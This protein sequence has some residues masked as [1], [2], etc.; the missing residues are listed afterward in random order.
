MVSHACKAVVLDRGCA[1]KSPGRWQKYRGLSSV[2]CGRA[3]AS[4]LLICSPSG[5]DT[6]TGFRIIVD[7][8]GNWVWYPDNIIRASLF[9][10]AS[11]HPFLSVCHFLGSSF[12]TWSKPLEALT[13]SF[14]FIQ[15]S[16]KCLW[17]PV[18]RTA[19]FKAGQEMS[20]SLHLYPEV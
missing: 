1:S 6:H 19:P 12:I 7:Q 20:Q 11:F 4:G 9:L 13:T 2:T 10:I 8:D 18:H 5:A 16:E 17:T 15:N 14:Q 3:W